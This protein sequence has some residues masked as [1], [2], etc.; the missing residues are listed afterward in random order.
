MKNFLIIVVC[1]VVIAGGLFF[2]QLSTYRVAP[3]T[4]QNWETQSLAQILQTATQKQIPAMIKVGSK[5]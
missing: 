5:M 1:V 2:Y 3:E 4:F